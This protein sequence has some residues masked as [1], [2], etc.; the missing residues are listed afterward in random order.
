[1]P[2]CSI[3]SDIIPT[4]RGLKLHMTR[5]HKGT[6]EPLAPETDPFDINLGVADDDPLPPYELPPT[7]PAPKPHRKKATV[8]Q[9]DS[10]QIADMLLFMLDGIIAMSLG[11]EAK[12]D[13]LEHEYIDPAMRRLVDRHMPAQLSDRAASYADVLFLA[14]G[15]SLWSIRVYKTQQDKKRLYTVPPDIAD[16]FEQHG[17][18]EGPG[19]TEPLN[20]TS[21]ASVLRS[22]QY[23]A[24]GVSGTPPIGVTPPLWDPPI[25]MADLMPGA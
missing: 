8:N 3:C 25:D 14:F 15:F 10:A 23:P 19:F 1:M 12:I 11:E 13:R 16:R 21:E 22:V 7:R 2:T 9:P 18:F 24:N 20:N 4:D 6:S 17:T 5:K